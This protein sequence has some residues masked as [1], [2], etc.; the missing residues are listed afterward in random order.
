MSNVDSDS[1]I[2]TPRMYIVITLKFKIKAFDPN[3]KL[4]KIFKNVNFFAEETHRYQRHD[5]L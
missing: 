2:H 3:K 5:F 4:Y 1:M